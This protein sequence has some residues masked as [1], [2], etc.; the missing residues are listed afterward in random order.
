M[1]PYWKWLANTKNSLTASA[2]KTYYYTHNVYQQYWEYVSTISLYR[3]HFGRKSQQ[4]GSPVLLV[5]TNTIIY[6]TPLAQTFTHKWT[7]FLVKFVTFAWTSATSTKQPHSDNAWTY[8]TSPKQPH[9]ATAHSPAGWQLSGCNLLVCVTMWWSNLFSLIN[10]Y[11]V[12]ILLV[13]FLH[14]V[15]TYQKI[16]YFTVPSILVLITLSHGYNYFT[17]IYQ[18][19]WLGTCICSATQ[20][21]YRLHFMDK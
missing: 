15:M 1:Q 4:L 17:I 18:L 8:V 14:A 12:K 21:S 2:L 10:I 9:P 11:K 7:R 20:G 6:N 5:V 13:L 3:S 16:Q 19:L